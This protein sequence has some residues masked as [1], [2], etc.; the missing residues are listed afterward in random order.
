[1]FVSVRK[2]LKAFV[3]IGWYCRRMMTLWKTKTRFRTRDSHF[4]QESVQ[5]ILENPEF[6]H[7]YKGSHDPVHS[8]KERRS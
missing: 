4:K 8:G 7:A 1:M 3:P 6:V 5:E 2:S